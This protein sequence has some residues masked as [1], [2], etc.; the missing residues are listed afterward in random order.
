[1]FQLS[2]ELYDT[3]KMKV[4]WS[5]RWQ[6]N[7]DNISNIKSSLSEGL[8]QTL[9]KKNSPKSL[10]HV[11]PEAYELY[12]KAT[13]KYSNR[14]DIEDIEVVRGLLEKALEIDTNCLKAKLLLGN[15]FLDKSL[16]EKA[17]ELYLETKLA[18]QKCD[19]QE[20]IGM[21]IQSIGNVDKFNRKMDDA[22]VNY[23]LANEIF[24]QINSKKLLQAN[25]NSIAGIYYLKRNSKKVLDYLDK[26]TELLMEL[27]DK[28]PQGINLNNKGLIYQ[29]TG[30][31]VKALKFHLDALLITKE[32]NDIQTRTECYNN[33][34]IAHYILENY[35]ESKE[36]YIKALK[37][38]KNLKDKIGQGR[39]FYNLGKVFLR[40]NEFEKAYENFYQC[41]NIF[42]KLDLDNFLIE[43]EIFKAYC[44]KIL[45]KDYSNDYYENLNGSE[46]IDFE[47][48]FY[49]FKLS[50]KD[51]FIENAY[52]FINN[53]SNSFDPEFKKQYLELE[54][55]KLIISD[56]ESKNTKSKDIESNQELN[57]L[58]NELKKYK[59][60]FDEGLI[61]EDDYKNKKRAI[62]SLMFKIY[63]A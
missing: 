4:V 55:T 5:D 43:S 45:N 49:L 37:I 18:A 30:N 29:S 22:L 32:V 12:L 17:K 16:P 15:T 27:E 3:K 28:R 39:I 52:N 6:E 56:W 23:K 20:L 62:R 41:T 33:I 14:K 26:S 13:Y 50:K 8:L 9:D 35:T 44:N 11:N 40:L 60:L 61:T 53:K 2:V 1:M 48:S 63:T 57:N 24:N 42:K 21:S 47:A 34:A 38:R 7:W 51:I 36:F 59:M 25:L 10:I 19:D 58:K 31:F 46:M 54:K